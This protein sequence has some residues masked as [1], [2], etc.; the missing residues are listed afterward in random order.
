MN[1]GQ[2]S[3]ALR[4][5]KISACQPNTYFHVTCHWYT[6]TTHWMY[7][8][9]E[10]LSSWFRVIK[11]HNKVIQ[12]K[13]LKISKIGYRYALAFKTRKWLLWAGKTV[14][15]ELTISSTHKTSVNHCKRNMATEILSYGTWLFYIHALFIGRPFYMQVFFSWNIRPNVG[16]WRCGAMYELG[17][18][19]GSNQLK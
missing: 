16:I 18:R 17:S 12:L 1:W 19:D 9:F 2:D 4:N 3:E 14:M 5:N 6:R 10:A 15:V 8:Y 13:A 11:M 7:M